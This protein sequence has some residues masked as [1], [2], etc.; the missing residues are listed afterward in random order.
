M[1]AGIRMYALIS[2]VGMSPLLAAST[3]AEVQGAGEA[4]QPYFDVRGG[5]NNCRLRFTQE[6]R[7]RVAYLGGSI[8]TTTGWRGLTYDIL[9]RRFPDTQ[10]DFINAGIGGTD[11]TMGAFRFETDVLKNGR[12]DL[13]FLEF[14]VNDAG[15]PSPDRHRIRAM[16]GIVRQARRHNPDI[17]I[18]VQYFID[19]GKLEKITAGQTPPAIIDHDQVAEHYSIPIINLAQEMSRR[20]NN[21]EFT[22]EAFSMDSCHPT[23]FGH[24]LY[25]KCIDEFLD[26]AWAAE[27]ASS[28]RISPYA[29]PTPVDPLNY[30]NGHYVDFVEAEIV[31]GWARDPAWKATKTCNYSGAVDVLVAAKPSAT[32]KLKFNGTLVGFTGIAGMDA[33]VF[34]YSIDDGPFI[35]QDNF[36]HY[37]KQF[38][39]PIC[40]TLAEELPPGDHVLTLRISEKKNEASQ[41]HAVRILKFTC[42]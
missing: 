3:W 27:P 22:W 14:A 33:G 24:E 25:A 35:E 29:M 30:E 39:R 7:G 19:K 38:H 28:A 40:R 9:K 12:V 32:F 17:D 21:G 6:K 42:N 5:L 2:A 11:S 16:E 18:I 20:L 37:C 36:D 13:L 34:E 1:K 10:F 31:D 8:T 41:G 15:R 4:S 23:P 26:A